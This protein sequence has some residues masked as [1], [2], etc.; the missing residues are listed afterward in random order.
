MR[1]RGGASLVIAHSYPPK[2][3]AAFLERRMREHRELQEQ[4]AAE[5]AA[6]IITEVATAL[7]IAKQVHSGRGPQKIAE[8]SMNTAAKQPDPL[9]EQAVILTRD[10]RKGSTWC[11]SWASGSATG[12]PCN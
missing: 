7:E 5:S 10:A 4:L 12:G 9:F 2:F 3:D 1:V 11:C 6:E 8:A